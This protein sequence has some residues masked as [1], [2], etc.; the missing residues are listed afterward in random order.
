[1]TEQYTPVPRANLPKSN[2]KEI[3][4]IHEEYSTTAPPAVTT[5]PTNAPHAIPMEEDP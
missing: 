4:T 2:Q 1:M 3:H 5:P